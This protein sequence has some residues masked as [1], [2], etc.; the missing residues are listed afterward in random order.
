MVIL[1]CL[2]PCKKSA[3]HCRGSKSSSSKRLWAHCR[4][5]QHG[6]LCRVSQPRCCLE[7][8]ALP[9]VHCSNIWIL[10]YLQAVWEE[11]ARLGQ[12][13][14]IHQICLDKASRNFSN[15][16]IYYHPH[17]HLFSAQQSIFL[18]PSGQEP[19]PRAQNLLLQLALV[20]HPPG[21][22]SRERSQPGLSWPICTITGLTH[23][24]WATWSCFHCCLLSLRL[25]DWLVL[26]DIFLGRLV[27]KPGPL[28]IIWRCLLLP[29]SPS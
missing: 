26:Q 1:A 4:Y 7:V 2:G 24:F 16:L 29:Y 18:F 3:V 12:T 20:A 17:Q 19:I 13:H 25:M 10:W 9:C 28:L 27:H 6:H 23:I 11:P 22:I 8:L 15:S 5:V 14:K 21:S